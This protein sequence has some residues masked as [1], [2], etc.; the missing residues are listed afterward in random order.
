MLLNSYV[1][2]NKISVIVP[3]YNV[4]AY[5]DK[6]VNS[7]IYNSYKELEIILI[8]DGSTD[9]TGE[10]IDKYKETDPRVIIVH[11]ENKGLSESRNLG[12]TMATG[13]YIA[14]VD[15]DDWVDL[16]YFEKMLASMLKGFDLVATSYNRVFKNATEPRDFLLNGEFKSSFI[17]R[18]M[19]GLLDEELRDPSQA[20]SLVTAWSKL[21]RTALIK[22]SGIKFLSTKEIGT[23]DLLFNIEYLSNFNNDNRVFIINE[24]LYFYYKANTTSLTSTYKK[25]LFKQWQNLYNKIK[26]FVKTNEEKE[27]FYNRICLSIIGLGLNELSNPNGDITIKNNLKTILLS[28]QYRKAYKKL[29]LNYF[30]MHWKLFFLAAKLPNITILLWLLKAINQVLNKKNHS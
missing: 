12:I 14:F 2:V 10:L 26:V 30:P 5:I 29:K 11:Q 16:S 22:N 7:I 24:P 25:D 13:A 1:L 9:N 6:C 4:S 23:E 8:N 3:C 27:A 20:D 28:E 17:K 19:I 15:S 18:R 21:Y